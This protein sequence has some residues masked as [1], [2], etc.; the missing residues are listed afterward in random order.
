MK[1]L[2]LKVA[3]IADKVCEITEKKELG[4][5]EQNFIFKAGVWV[6]YKAHGMAG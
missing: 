5:V 6:F 2:L 4:Y 3:K 1:N